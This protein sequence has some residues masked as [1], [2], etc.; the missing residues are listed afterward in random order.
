MVLEAVECLRGRTAVRG[1][2]LL[3]AGV[4]VLQNGLSVMTIQLFSWRIWAAWVDDAIRGSWRT[5]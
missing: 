5:G 3:W 2:D 1:P 4:Q